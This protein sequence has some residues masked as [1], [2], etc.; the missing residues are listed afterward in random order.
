MSCFFATI[1]TLAHILSVNKIHHMV[2]IIVNEFKG[3]IVK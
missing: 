2:P 1:F 3:Y